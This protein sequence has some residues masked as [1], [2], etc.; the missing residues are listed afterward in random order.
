MSWSGFT[1]VLIPLTAVL[2]GIYDVVTIKMGGTHTSISRIMRDW[3]YD[4]QQFVWAFWYICGHLFWPQ[5]PKNSEI[6][7]L[8]KEIFKLKKLKYKGK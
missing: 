7:R 8:K 1:K 4:Y 6:D 2:W 5:P 3:S